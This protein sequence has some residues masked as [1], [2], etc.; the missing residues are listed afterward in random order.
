M[1]RFFHP[2][3][4]KILPE[5]FSNMEVEKLCHFG[6][7]AMCSTLHFS[8]SSSSKWEGGEEGGKWNHQSA[9]THSTCLRYPLASDIWYTRSRSC[10]TRRLS[11]WLWFSRGI[12]ARSLN[13]LL[14]WS[15]TGNLLA[16][17]HVYNDWLE[18]VLPKLCKT[19]QPTFQEKDY[20]HEE[21]KKCALFKKLPEGDI[22][23]QLPKILMRL[24]GVESNRLF[25]LKT[26][27]RQ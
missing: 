9:L 7:D 14:S 24:D 11:G 25:A 1:A 10:V 21:T 6:D 13:S 4:A 20:L 16:A 8:A 26:K 27:P 19:D 22:L 2:K 23:W 5:G 18:S 15:R 17:L 12:L 3:S